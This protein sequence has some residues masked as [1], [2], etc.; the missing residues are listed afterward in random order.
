MTVVSR[1]QM[2]ALGISE[3]EWSR[4][5]QRIEGGKVI[6]VI[7]E[8]LTVMT[9][10][11]PPGE[12]SL[13]AYLADRLD[14]PGPPTA[15]LNEV[16]FRYLQRNPRGLDD[17]YADIFQAL[18]AAES[19]PLPA[20]LRQLAEIRDF[21]LFVTT[22][23]DPYLALALNEVRFGRRSSGSTRVLAYER[24][25]SVDI[26]ERLAELD[27]PLV[28]HLFGKA[29]PAPMFAVTDEDVLEFVHTL[30]APECQPPHLAD[31]LREQRL[32]VLG[33]RLT[34]WL[35]RFFLRVSSADRLRD[36]RRADYVIDAAAHTDTEQAVFFEQ[37]GEVKLLPMP[38]AQFV[39]ELVQRWKARHPAAA[40]PERAP[41]DAPAPPG[42]GDVFLS[43]ASED[44]AVVK[45]LRER[46]EREAGVRVWLDRDALRGGDQWERQIADTLRGCAL[47]IP[48]ISAAARSSGFR[49]V[50]AEWRQAVRLAAGRPADRTFLLPLVIDDTRPDDPAIDPELRA[51]HWRRLHDETDLQRFL[52]E[53]RAAVESSLS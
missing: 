26:P 46:L 2:G 18:P 42:A 32:L 27:H 39:D 51:L 10:G 36:A 37:F 9:G 12:M 24:N 43:Y 14:L 44:L 22:S 23:F 20:P 33:T 47:C 13:A 29:Q 45:A 3:K 11:D 35:T 41:H 4:I 19:F 48:V 49:Y 28:Y 40:A 1:P 17:L 53:A 50:R 25:R 31:A 7:G 15:S 52:A 5:L 34:G 38:A 30:Q 8:H 16:A 6:P 21:N